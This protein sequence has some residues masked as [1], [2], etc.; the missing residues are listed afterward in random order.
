MA[1]TEKKL[2][3]GNGKDNEQTAPIQIVI[4]YRNGQSEISGNISQSRI[5]SYGMLRDAEIKLNYFYNQVQ[6]KEAMN[7]KE[8]IKPDT[9]GFIN[10]LK[11]LVK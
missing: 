10:G 4:T 7:K 11:R 5:I 6:I 2:E 1:E 9:N 3:D 8:I